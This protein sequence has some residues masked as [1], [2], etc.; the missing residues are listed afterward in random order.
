M[1][2]NVNVNF[3][4]KGERNYVHGTDI[5]ENMLRT[6]HDHFGEYP[7]RI[8]GSFHRLLKNNG[9]LCIYSDGEVIDNERAYVLFTILV[10]EKTYHLAI[11][12]AESQIGSSYEYDEDK[13][14]NG[15]LIRDKTIT[16][17]VKSTY[18]YI[19]Q[20]V[21]MTK[22]LHLAIY[23]EAEGKWLFTKIQINDAVAP[24]RYFDKIL[25]ITAERNFQDKLTQSTIRINGK[26]I[27]F[28]YFSST[29]L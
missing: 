28:I 12:D 23:P 20:L 29:T 3:Q 27:G 22:K 6:V 7:S 17:K 15:C 19:E 26:G 4:F 21:A 11:F 1:L 2:H 5:Y 14:L 10:G 9:I 16:I 8:T 24:S 13:V 25:S 18:K